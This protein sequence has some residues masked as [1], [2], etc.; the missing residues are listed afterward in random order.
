MNER[1]DLQRLLAEAEA[2]LEALPRADQ[3]RHPHSVLARRKALEAK[4]KSLHNR[5][6][7]MPVHNSLTAVELAA[8]NVDDGPCLDGDDSPDGVVANSGS[9]VG[10]QAER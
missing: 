10:A 2:K 9:Q 3:V 6:S 4:I 7:T 1:A 5:I 8:V